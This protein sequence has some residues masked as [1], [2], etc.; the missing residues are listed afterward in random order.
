ME[1][2]TPLSRVEDILQSTID[3]T[4]Y[5]KPP[6]SRV[7]KL[8][9]DLKEVIE[10]SGDTSAYHPAGSVDSVAE[11]PAPSADYLGYVYD[12]AQ[13]FTTTSDFKEGAGKRYPAGSNI[14]IID[15]GTPETPSYKYDVLSGFIDT[16]VFVEKEEGKGLSTNDYTDA[17]KTKLASLENY[18]DTEIRSALNTKANDADLATVAKSGAYSDLSGTPTI[19]SKTSDLTNDAGFVTNQ[20]NDSTA[21]ASTAYSSN[22]TDTLLGDKEDKPIDITKAAYDAL[23]DAEKHNGRTYYITD[24]GNTWIFG[25]DI[26]NNDENPNTRVSY[27]ADVDNTYFTPAYMDFASGVFKY[28][29]WNLNPGEK[30]MPNPCMQKYDNSVDYYLSASNNAYKE[31]GV[32]SSDIADTSYGG[33]AMMEWN[34]IYTKR[35]ESQGVYHFRCSNKKL[36]NDFE[37]WCNYDRLDNVIPHFY[38]P[39]YFGSSDGTR[40]RS[41]SG[42]SN[43]VNDTAPNEITKAKANGSDWYTEVTADWMLICDLLVM[44]CKSTNIQAKYGTGRTKSSNSSAINTGTMNDK[45]L[46]WGSNDETSGIKLFGME[47]W[48]CGN[49]WRRMAGYMY[50]DGVQK[51]KITRGTKDGSTATD[52]NTTGAGYIAIPNSTVSSEGWTKIMKALPYGRITT[53]VGGSASTYESDY[54][55]GNNSGTRYALAG[56]RWG[57]S[58]NAGPFCVRLYDAPSRAGAYVG[59]ALSCKPLAS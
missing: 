4:E 41:L 20:I 35:W 59:A 23:S 32:T 16:S 25:Y 58:S 38:T 15:A 34:L 50:V 12:I 43:Y 21:S 14:A 26:D 44:M 47:N 36:D 6:Q 7:E 30:F 22:K 28:G 45:G 37:C 31:D 54:F 10:D 3:S 11:L 49:L 42:K 40:L 39:I 18:D 2:S 1:N 46:F 29:N 19:P 53:G 52:Y 56:G 17:E 57:A 9:I 51:L 48:Y 24:S 8:L 27:P 13:A 33:N 55:Y 5:D